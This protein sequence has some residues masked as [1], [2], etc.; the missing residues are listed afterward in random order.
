MMKT[1][2]NAWPRRIF[3]KRISIVAIVVSALLILIFVGFSIYGNNVGNFVVSIEEE[4]RLALTLSE[5]GEFED[6]T[7]VT[8]ILNAKGLTQ[9]TNATYANIPHDIN[10]YTGNQNDE[11][12]KRYCAYSFYIK[13]TSPIDIAYSMKITITDLYKEVDEALR[14]MVITDGIRVIYAKPRKDGKPE[15]HPDIEVPYTTIPFVSATTVC[16]E[17]I[18]IFATGKV[19]KYTVVMWL[20]GYDAECVDSIK[21]GAIKLDMKFSVEN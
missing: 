9:A 8:S 21:G 19:K 11:Y 12:A 1:R 10:E 3:L 16:N 6:P 17:K 4:T 13:N 15:S 18:D 20:E 2:L 14:V 5:T 7:K